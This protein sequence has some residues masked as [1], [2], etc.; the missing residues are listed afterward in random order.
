MKL[1]LAAALINTCA[2]FA[3]QGKASFG[4]TATAGKGKTI[5]MVHW[6]VFERTLNIASNQ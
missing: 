5:D 6:K 4:I 1:I 3:P 2:A